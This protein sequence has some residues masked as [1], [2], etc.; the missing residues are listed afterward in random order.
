M[1]MKLSAMSYSFDKPT[2]DSVLR[3]LK[4]AERDM[5]VL[6]RAQC[7]CVVEIMVLAV[8]DNLAPT[9]EPTPV[10]YP[11]SYFKITSTFQFMI[12][13]AGAVT[14]VLACVTWTLLKCFNTLIGPSLMRWYRKNF[15]KKVLA[16]VSRGP[17]KREMTEETVRLIVQETIQAREIEEYQHESKMEETRYAEKPPPI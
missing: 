7:S 15:A 16:I 2:V 13:T 14:T 11:D 3:K 6:V 1:Q 8:I 9:L 5:S 4:S 10:P 17:A 12:V